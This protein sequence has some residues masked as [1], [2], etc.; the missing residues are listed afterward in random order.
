ML[1]RKI[2]VAEALLA[3]LLVC[4]FRYQEKTTKKQLKFIPREQAYQL[5]SVMQCSP[6]WNKVD[7]ESL[8]D[9]I[10]LLPGWGHYE[11][12]INTKSDSAQIYFNQG[13]SMYYAFHIIESMASFKKAQQFDPSN[14]M[15]YWA[16]ALAYGPNINDMGYD[17]APEAYMAA[18]KA[19][20]LSTRATEREKA[21][22]RAMCVRYA[23]QKTNDQPRLN[24]LYSDE[25]KKVYQKLPADADVAALYADAMMLLHPW[26]YWKH[27]GQPEPWTPAIR[28]V[29]EKLLAQNPDHPGANH[30]YI[31]TLEAS[32]FPEKAIA[33]ADRLADMMPSVSHMVHMPSHIYIRSGYYAKGA[34]ANERSMKGYEDYLQLYPD[35]VNN[36]PLYLIHNLHMQSACA[37]MQA[38]YAYGA[39]SAMKCRNSFDTSFMGMAAPLGTIA[40]YIYMTPVFNNVRFGKWDSVLAETTIPENYVYANAL[41]HWARGMALCMKHQPDDARKELYMLQKQMKHHDMEVVVPPFN[42]PLSAAKVAEKI[43]EGNIAWQNNNHALALNL[44]KKAVQLEDALIYNEPRDWLIPA[45]Q[46][47]GYALLKQGNATEA[48]KN[49]REDLRINPHNHWALYGLWQSLENQ[50]KPEASK[51]KLEFEAAFDQND[52]EP[53]SGISY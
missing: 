15:I 42:A 37:M 38:N 52:I 33:S 25:M 21:L 35:V 40:Q 50:H 17:A 27:N 16:Q 23:R 6:D 26:D 18:Q 41:Q 47:F 9:G 12:K 44:L 5:K 8:A 13:I 39:S 48:E 7:A 51:T 29:L 28:Q 30:Y 10:S 22:I 43:L 4:A 14:A 36:M 45:R 32:P 34:L 3:L 20:K 31:H 53:A 2:L 19:L 1:N 11:W 24:R 46:Y 49:F